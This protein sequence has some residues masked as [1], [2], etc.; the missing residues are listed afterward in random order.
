MLL[1]HWQKTIF[2]F[3]YLSIL[4]CSLIGIEEDQ[5]SSLI[6]AFCTSQLGHLSVTCWVHSVSPQQLE[7]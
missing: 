4:T 1:N 6:A 7:A 2:F 3:F 5:S